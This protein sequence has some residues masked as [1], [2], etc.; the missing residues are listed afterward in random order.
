MKTL[1]A[2]LTAVFAAAASLDAHEKHEHAPGSGLFG[3]PPE[4]IHVL[5]NPM[6]V[7]GLMLGALGLAAA[8]IARNRAVRVLALSIVV[9]A[10]TSAWPTQHFGHNAYQH[11]RQ[12]SDEQGQLW[13]DEHMSRAEKFLFLF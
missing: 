11:V 5:L 12:I 7:Y 1:A 4:H 3:H 2:I 9:V 10:G 13:L 8:L 6:P